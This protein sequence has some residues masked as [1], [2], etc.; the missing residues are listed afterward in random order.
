MSEVVE[1]GKSPVCFVF[2]DFSTSLNSKRREPI[3]IR[4]LVVIYYFS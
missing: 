1:K 4:R 2:V 3:F